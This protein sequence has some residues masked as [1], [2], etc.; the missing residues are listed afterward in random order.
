MRKTL[1]VILAALVCSGV[2]VFAAPERAQAAINCSDPG[3][4]CKGGSLGGDETW[5]P[6]NIY[7]ISGSDLVVPAGRTLTIQAGTIVKFGASHLEIIIDG[8]LV[9]AGAAGNRVYFTSANDDSLGGDTNHDTAPP[10]AGQWGRVYFRGSSSGIL[11]YVELRYGSNLIYTDGG[12][13]VTIDHGVFKNANG[14]AINSSPAYEP[15]LTNMASTD[16]T[17]SQYNGLCLR[18]EAVGVNAT[19]DETE[20]AYVLLEDVTVTSGFTLTLGP[21]VVIKPQAGYIALIV[22][23]TLLANGTPANPVYFT[24]FNDDGLGGQTNN[25]ANPPGAGQWDRVYFRGGSSGILSYVELR[26]GN[27]LIYTDGGTS[28]TIDHGV[29]KNANGCAINSSPAYEPT[30]TNMASTDFTGSQY[31]GLC[32]RSEAVGVSATWDETEAAYVLL[33]D[34][35]VTSGFTLTI[36]PGVV[37]KPQAGYIGLTV[38]GTLLA[39][40]TP[41]NPV[42]FT[43]FNDDSLGGQ[44]NNNANPPGAGQWNRVYFRAGSVGVLNYFQARYG[45]S[46]V[47]VEN[48]TA[49]LNNCVLWKNNRGLSS[50]GATAAPNLSGC[51]I[52]DNKEYGVYNNEAGHWIHA[53]NNSWGSTSGPY[54][55]SPPGKDGDYN[56]GSG[57]RVND[58]VL[59]RPF[60]TTVTYTNWVYLP[61]INRAVIR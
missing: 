26:Y 54:D 9:A 39:N 17:G 18:S 55:P 1:F 12:T 48:A 40:G 60:G 2:M 10:G 44:T 19:W 14:C 58:Y 56:N 31:N 3:V 61:L 59:Y 13:S 24:S 37:V 16:F 41:A 25:N 50:Y 38:D 7:V 33:E 35:T 28:V 8:V 51:S 30:L 45:G 32:L 4:I 23:G 20:T 6:G 29:F 34:V 21:G 5:S 47:Y 27:N 22:D 43:S 49:Q 57:D 11:S 53:E 42:Y 36:G 52:S 15:T 46:A